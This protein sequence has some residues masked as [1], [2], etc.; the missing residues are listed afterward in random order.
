MTSSGLP[1]V[2][3]MKVDVEGAEPLVL[4]G[5]SGLLSSSERRPRAIMLEL[6]DINLSTYGTNVTEIIE[7]MRAF[8]YHPFVAATGEGVRAFRPEDRNRVT[9]I[10]FLTEDATRSIGK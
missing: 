4:Q 2:D 7:R 10:F 6:L 5:A 9:N 3:V 8:S 1:K